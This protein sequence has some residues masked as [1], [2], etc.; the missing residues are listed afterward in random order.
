MELGPRIVVCTFRHHI[1][2]YPSNLGLGKPFRIDRLVNHCHSIYLKVRG[3]G[4]EKE[5]EC[6][7]TDKPRPAK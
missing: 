2:I 1:H 7:L 5:S 4:P 3:P 6:S